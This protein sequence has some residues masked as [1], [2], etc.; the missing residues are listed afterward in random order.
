MWLGATILDSIAQRQGLKQLKCQK[1]K[2]SFQEINLG[3]TD[4]DVN[5]TSSSQTLGKYRM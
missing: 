1:K 5:I 4:T 3:H 2:K